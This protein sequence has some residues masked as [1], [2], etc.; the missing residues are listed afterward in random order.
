MSN[1]ESSLIV[2]F[3]TSQQAAILGLEELFEGGFISTTVFQQMKLGG[4]IAMDPH[5]NTGQWRNRRTIFFHGDE[6][7][8]VTMFVI[9]EHDEHGIPNPDEK[10]LW[11]PWGAVV[12]IGGKSFSLK[13]NLE[14][15]IYWAS[16]PPGSI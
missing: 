6:I 14:P 5:H 11:V 15:V 2:N 4:I 13:R 12:R 8:N 9:S 16:A 10:L 7:Q 3:T 1:L